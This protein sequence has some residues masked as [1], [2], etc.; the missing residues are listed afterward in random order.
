MCMCQQLCVGGCHF[1]GFSSCVCVGG[2]V[3][4]V[5]GSS[6]GIDCVWFLMVFDYV[7]FLMGFDYVWFFIVVL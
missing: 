5:C 7:W 4:I 2:W 6:V 3:L 1:V